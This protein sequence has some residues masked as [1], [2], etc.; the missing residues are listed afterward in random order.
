MKLLL[1]THAFLW[2][3]EGKQDLSRDALRAILQ[4]ENSLHLSI[5]SYWE[6]C[7][8]ISLGRL[9]LSPGWPRLFEREMRRNGIHWLELK[10]E[11]IRGIVDLPFIHRDPFDRLLIAQALHERCCIVTGDESI[12]KYDVKTIW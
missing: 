3:L 11:H 5:A 8:K 9:A 12:S 4:E 10:K 6:M 7:I 2:F 1:D